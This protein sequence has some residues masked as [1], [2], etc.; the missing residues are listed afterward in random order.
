MSSSSSSLPENSIWDL[1]LYEVQR[2]PHDVVTD[3][4]LLR[5]S[6]RALHSELMCPI[7]LDLMKNAQTTK[8]CLHRFCQECIITAL[9]SGNK[10]CPTCRKKL[11]SKRSLRSDP[12]FDALIAKIYPNRDELLQQQDKPRLTFHQSLQYL[13]TRKRRADT[14]QDVPSTVASV[15]NTPSPNTKVQKIQQQETNDEEVE[16]IENTSTSQEEEKEVRLEFQLRPH[17]SDDSVASLDIR[18]LATSPGATVAHITKFLS[19]VQSPDSSINDN[20]NDNKGSFSI[21][22]QLGSDEYI[23]LSES[24]S[25]KQI[26]ENFWT[27]GEKMMLYFSSVPNETTAATK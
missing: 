4:S 1:S 2:K 11:A 7:C 10:E 16:L 17:P 20:N 5:I 3:G 26:C 15:S 25:L 27:P 24:T 12:N 8:E 6:P 22:T 13:S 18:N 23:K 9:R 14:P 19:L 21:S